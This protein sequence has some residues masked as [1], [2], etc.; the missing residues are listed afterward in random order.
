MKKNEK[1]TYVTLLG[2]EECEKIVERESEEAIALLRA[3]RGKMII[4]NGWLRS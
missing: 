4:W 2:I 3:C 1:T